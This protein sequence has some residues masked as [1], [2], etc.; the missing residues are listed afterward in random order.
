MGF[1]F[2]GFGRKRKYSKKRK[3]TKKKVSKTLKK[4]CA[5][6][7]VK[8]GR[9]SA[10]QLKKQCAKKIRAM[11]KRIKRSKSKS[12]KRRTTR[13][14]TRFGAPVRRMRSTAMAVMAAQPIQPRRSLFRRAGDRVMGG[15]RYVRRN[16]FRSAG[17]ALLGA[18]AL[19]TGVMAGRYA[20]ARYRGGKEGV[21]KLYASDKKRLANASRNAQLRAYSGRAALFRATH[22][23]GAIPPPPP[24]RLMPQKAGGYKGKKVKTGMSPRLQR[25]Y[26]N[27]NL[28]PVKPGPMHGPDI[29]ISET[30]IYKR[31]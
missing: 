1:N 2:F 30:S 3:G 24:M 8:L 27:K 12:P 19:G 6:Y 28:E 25:I 23:A 18:G 13:R 26:V 21:S 16:P 14:R 20:N 22:K 4:I 10:T 31:A 11:I 15:L 7:G 5:R 17:Y 9:K 29:P